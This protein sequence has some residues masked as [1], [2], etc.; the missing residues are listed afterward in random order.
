MKYLTADLP[1]AGGRIKERP[2]DF[3]VTE[4][5]L[6]KPSGE[7]DHVYLFIEKTG[8]GS[9]EAADAIARALGKAR[10]LVGIAG[11]K[12]AQAVTRQWMSLEHVDPAKAEGLQLEG[13][14]IL[15]VSRH[16]NKLKI[17]HL[18]ANRFEI[19]IRG[20]RPG[21]GEAAARIL[22]VLRTKGVPNWF[23]YQ[24]FGR[25]ADNHLLGRALVLGQYKEFC[26]EFLGRPA[27]SDSRRL[28]EARRLY[29]KGDWEGAR[30]FMAG[31][32]DQLR[33]LSELIRTKNPER[34]A[35]NLPRQLAKLFIGAFQSSLFNK[36]LERRLDSRDRVEPGD[37]AYIHGRGAVFLVED[38]EKEAPRAARF[39]ISPSGPI[40][41]HRVTLATGRPGE[42]EHAVLA[43]ESITPEVFERV[44][45][46]RLRGDRRPLRFPIS[47]ARIDTVGGNDL[48]LAF[49]LPPGS[50]AT[51]VLAEITK[52]ECS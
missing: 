4:L 32:T 34:A 9:L 49:T 23:D 28:S 24:R 27:A 38:V 47:D 15:E 40:V 30:A 5:P 12:D 3:R 22:D 7:G 50:Y 1:G 51:V 11:L 41:G 10:H 17:G 14:K 33:V 13:I 43:E 19:R 21:A 6:Y 39:E 18:A 35:R 36:V 2:E 29:D 31:Q 44:K 16:R 37:Y 45:A 25:R 26:D 48:L 52:S 20:C 46:L 42:I 8:L